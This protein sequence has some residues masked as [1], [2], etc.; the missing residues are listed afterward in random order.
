MNKVNSIQLREVIFDDWELLLAWRNDPE[1]IK[2]SLQS[3]TVQPDQ[4]QR[5]L[6]KV[7]AD[8][9]RK[10]YIALTQNTPVG[11]CRVDVD[12]VHQEH[13]ISW[14]IAP[15]HRGQGIGKNM[16]RKLLQTFDENSV[17]IRAEIKK[18]NIPSRKIAEFVGFTFTDERE[19]ILHYHFR[20]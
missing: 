14:T 1:T 10:L 3:E 19:G 16:V 11:T 18:E 9:D 20:K 17:C 6:K 8:P 13:V 4:H 2:N 15:S 12:K 5:W 7:I